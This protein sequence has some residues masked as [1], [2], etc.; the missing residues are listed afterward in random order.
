M[1][2]KSK[3]FAAAV[4][5]TLAGGA[6]AAVGTTGT[7]P[8]SAATLTCGSTCVDFFN[9]QHGP[10]A[11]P[12]LLLDLQGGGSGNLGQPI[13]LARASRTNLG[14]D[15]VVNSV[16]PASDYYVSG[17]GAE[18][19]ALRYGC[20]AG[21]APLDDFTTCPA[22]SVDDYAFQIVYAPGGVITPA[23]DCVSP[24][25]GAPPGNGTSVV[26]EPCGV[27]AHN[28]WIFNPVKTAGGCEFTLISLATDN[29]FANPYVLTSGYAGL[30]TFSL[31]SFGN[32][33]LG[34]QLWG[35]DTGAVPDP[36][37]VK[38]CTPLAFYY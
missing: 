26:L 14:E 23:Y 32:T 2:V 21:S 7:L 35:V 31:L 33:V 37:P 25:F 17:Y 1:S 8:A 19:L 20:L 18:G 27:N 16:E 13:N 4:A 36:T 28:L 10:A 5:L 29:S 30:F 15:F 6:G 24:S 22:G 9:V 11:N 12:A 38:S 34:N 3:I